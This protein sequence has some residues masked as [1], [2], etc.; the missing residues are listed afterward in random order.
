MNWMKSFYR[1]NNPREVVNYLLTAEMKARVEKSRAESSNLKIPMP[2]GVTLYP[3]QVAGVDYANDLKHT[4]LGDDMGLGKTIQAI[5]FMNLNKI[6]RALIIAPASLLSNWEKE[7]RKAHIYGR[8]LKIQVIRGAKVPV[9]VLSDIQIVSYG[10]CINANIHM[11]LQRRM[12]QVLIL[13][14]VHFLK[15][16][17]SKRTKAV[18]GQR[19][20]SDR[21]ER[22]LSLS[23]T[24]IV[25]R[26]YE[27]YAVTRKLAPK[28]LGDMMFKDFAMRYCAGKED[29][30]G[31]LKYE[32]AS[33][34]KELGLRLRAHYMVR[35]LKEQVLKDLPDK[36]RRLVVFNPPKKLKDEFDKN[37]KKYAFAEDSKR[38]T[39]LGLDDHIAKLRREEGEA[40]APLAVEYIK[41]QFE[42][43]RKKAIIFCHH[44]VVYDYLMK[45][46][47]E[48][49]PVGIRGETLDR[50][51]P[52]DRFQNDPSVQVFIGSITACGVG[53]TLTA[54]DYVCF[55]ESSF[56]PG[57]NV[58]AEDRAHRITQKNAVQVDYIVFD[59][60]ISILVYK[61]Q[62]AKAKNIKEIMS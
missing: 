1:Q 34:M 7:L 42:A 8:D 26:P 56:V 9:D 14:E 58:Q 13:D 49:N 45:E 36:T 29:H 37:E 10:S 57:E 16:W 33:N 54:S 46:F 3:F 2:K 44:K 40:I 47:S 60:S 32:G 5:A 20:L 62:E 25:N 39:F 21:C 18:L 55:V 30:N 38:L 61:I 35:R 28:A 50:Q 4:L 12:N 43:G 41:E 24:A 17:T 6:S 31:N 22:S 11:G 59:G 52:V 15:N 27:I 51:T 19:L 48:F 53:I 23:G